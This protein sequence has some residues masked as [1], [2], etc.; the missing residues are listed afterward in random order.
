MFLSTPLRTHFLRSPGVFGA[1][2][3]SIVRFTSQF[4]A[5]ASKHLNYIG[6]TPGSKVGE[7][8]AMALLNNANQDSKL[9]TVPRYS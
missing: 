9:I 8:L 5:L 7:L 4:K 3:E 2:N 6:P 1:Q